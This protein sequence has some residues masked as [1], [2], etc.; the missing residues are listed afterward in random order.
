MT[1]LVKA[2]T[3]DVASYR[4]YTPEQMIEA[5]RATHGLISPAADL[6]GCGRRTM[7]RYIKEY[8]EI[9]EA[10]E[11]EDE[12]FNDVAEASLYQAVK[13][14]DPWAVCFRLKTKGK[15]RGY[16]ER[17]ELGGANG[18]PVSIQLVYDE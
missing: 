15:K 11:D 1:E 3:R 7:Q 2:E 4:K 6:L 17:A 5:L 10:I 8:P 12:A 13:R 16:V 18:G 9:L 14:G